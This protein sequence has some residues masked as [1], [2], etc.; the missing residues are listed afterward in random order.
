MDMTFKVG[1][2]VVS[3]D[4]GDGMVTNIIS[5]PGDSH[6]LT[7]KFTSGMMYRFKSNG[8]YWLSTPDEDADIRLRRNNE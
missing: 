4:F 1:S 3:K 6:P 7:V 2:L 8:Q 5:E